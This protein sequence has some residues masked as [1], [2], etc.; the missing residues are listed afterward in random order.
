MHVFPDLK[1]LPYSF[2]EIFRN[3]RTTQ[4]TERYAVTCRWCGSHSKTMMY[5]SKFFFSLPD[6]VEMLGYSILLQVK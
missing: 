6:E 4:G 5:S 1:S 3:Q 2:S